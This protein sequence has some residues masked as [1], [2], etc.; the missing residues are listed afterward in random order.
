M[1]RIVWAVLAWLMLASSI[2]AASFDC[3]KA[4]SKVE[5]FICENAEIS[6]L[7]EDMDA[8]YRTAL[9]RDPKRA[10]ITK[11]EQKEWM[12]ERN[13]CSDD[14][15]LK[16]SYT[17]R[18][19]LLALS[20]ASNIPVQLPSRMLSGHTATLLPN[21]KILIA[22]GG[23]EGDSKALDSAVLYDPATNSYSSAGNMRAG[24]ADHFAIPLSNGK[25]LLGGGTASDLMHLANISLELYDPALNRFDMLTGSIIS[26]VGVAL[27]DGRVLFFTQDHAVLYYPALEGA[28]GYGSSSQLLMPRLGG[29]VTLLPNGKVLIAGGFGNGTQLANAELY[30]PA[31]GKFT[32]TGS[33][34]TA[35]T[36]H[37]AVLLKN[38]RVLI[39]GGSGPKGFLASAELYDPATGLFKS[40]GNLIEPREFIGMLLANGKVLLF[41]L[42][43]PEL[44]DPTSGV[45]TLARKPASRSYNSETPLPNG[46]VLLLGA[47]GVELYDPT[48]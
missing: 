47:D 1:K 43:T 5:I 21:G 35:R 8:A 9:L 40:A 13:R 10:G 44:Y 33:L 32:V 18:L 19:G 23:K 34:A 46:K 29:S 27:A 7:D 14:A 36:N 48:N 45:F 24:R 42:D 16:D 22:G 3:S 12:K 17:A 4:S 2:Q 26:D 39:V 15:C 25:V 30:D 28:A 20:K 37:T 6:R 38:G 31:T 41:R 11:R